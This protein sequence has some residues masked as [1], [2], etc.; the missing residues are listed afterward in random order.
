MVDAPKYLSFF[1][2]LNE[3]FEVNDNCK[4]VKEREKDV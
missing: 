4:F 1:P 2:E 3:K